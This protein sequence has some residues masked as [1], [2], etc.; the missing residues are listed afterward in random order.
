MAQDQRIERQHALAFGKHHQR[1]D[2]DLANL[3]MRPDELAKHNDR[4]DDGIDVARRGAAELI[5]QVLSGA[6]N[7][8]EEAVYATG[9]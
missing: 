6:R 7:R 8:K 1:I 2:I 5:E 4:V 3:R 9:N